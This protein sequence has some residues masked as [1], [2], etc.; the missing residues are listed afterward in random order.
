M[1]KKLSLILVLIL[2]LNV[3][4]FAA[5]RT[6]TVKDEKGLIDVKD[7]DLFISVKDLPAS[8]FTQ[9][10]VKQDIT[11]NLKKDSNKLLPVT[12]PDAYR[13]SIYENKNSLND[14]RFE[15]K[16]SDGTLRY[17]AIHPDE[18]DAVVLYTVYCIS[19]PEYVSSPYIE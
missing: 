6:D 8:E 12:S 16:M 9:W 15:E 4:V 10:C 2:I 5:E 3:S 1:F 11:L 18:K 13:I 14:F 17:Y 7:D 19:D